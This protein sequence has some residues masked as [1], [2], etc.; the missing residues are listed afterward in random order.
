[1]MVYP[2]SY[3]CIKPGNYPVGQKVSLQVLRTYG[4]NA[5]ERAEPLVAAA[6]A[7]RHLSV[8]RCHGLA[9]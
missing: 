7:A 9:A 2:Y 4:R 1:V 6:K 8:S 3:Q 5:P